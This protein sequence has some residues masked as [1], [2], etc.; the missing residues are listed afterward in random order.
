V[1]QKSY[2]AEDAAHGYELAVDAHPDDYGWN[3]WIVYGKYLRR[4]HEGR[5]F[6][7]APMPGEWISEEEKPLGEE[8][9]FERWHYRPLSRPYSSL[10]LEFARWPEEYGMDIDPPESDKNMAAALEWAHHYG[11]LG[12]DPP[13]FTVWGD[14]PG[15][16]RTFLG[17]PGPD[18]LQHGSNR[19]EAR[20]GPEE[21]VERFA[22]EAWVANMTLRLYEAATNPDGPDVDTI[23]SFM[24][25]QRD[26]WDEQMNLP[27]IRE[28]HGKTA[29]TA[30]E[31]ALSVVEEIVEQQV[32]GRCWPI[33][34]QD[35]NSHSEGWAFDSLLG[36]MWLQMLWLMRGDRR[37]E[38]CGKVLD[39][40][41]E[42][43]LQTAIENAGSGG[44]RKSRSDRRFC[45]DTTCRQSWNY[46]RGAGKSS[47]AE[48]RRQRGK[49]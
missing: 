41:P 37:C 15:A 21:T 12:L 36:A 10:F 39:M 44:R 2:K 7:Y 35:G 9:F 8:Q 4:V 26:R 13:D 48:R 30:R 20:G 45:P 18:R 1:P 31:W 32:R 14:S 49:S 47:A 40:D 3:D 24:S 25:D 11:V 19:N 28:L 6:V 23:I 5:R 46:H 22:D 27:S 42:Q 17:R 43:E 29:K 16:I 34:V 38:W 33:P